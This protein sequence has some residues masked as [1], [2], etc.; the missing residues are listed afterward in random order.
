MHRPESVVPLVG[1]RHTPRSVESVHAQWVELKRHWSCEVSSV[2]V[3]AKATASITDAK[4]RYFMFVNKDIVVD[5]IF[6]W[7]NGSWLLRGKCTSMESWKRVTQVE[8]GS[9]SSL[10]SSEV[11]CLCFGASTG[12]EG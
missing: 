1:R 3:C 5:A 10:C 12:C 7:G 8:V 4:V 9:C 6:S 11:Y 2:A